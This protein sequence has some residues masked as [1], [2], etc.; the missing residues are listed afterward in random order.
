MRGARL[1]RPTTTEPSAQGAR[2]LRPGGPYKVGSRRLSVAL[3]ERPGSA[4][5]RP[6]SRPAWAALAGPSSSRFQRLPDRSPGRVVAVSVALPAIRPGG[7]RSGTRPGRD[8]RELDARPFGQTPAPP[9]IRPG[10]GAGVTRSGDGKSIEGP[11]A[12]GSE[13]RSQDGT[14]QGTGG[15]ALTARTTARARREGIRRWGQPWW[16]PSSRRARWS[17]GRASLRSGP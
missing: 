12:S 4:Q 5:D 6:G 15:R 11:G 9:A 16:L 10:G 7:E 2:P 14:S 17:P 3:A 13:A 1:M 8:P